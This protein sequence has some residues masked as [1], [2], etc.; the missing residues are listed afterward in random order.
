LS[1]TEEQTVVADEAAP[2][3]VTQVT[4][5]TPAPAAAPEQPAPAPKA[6]RRGWHISGWHWGILAAILVVVAAAFFTIGWFASD[7][8]DHG[9][10]AKMRGVNEQMNRG[11]WGRQPGGFYQQGGT[12]QQG[13]GQWQAYP[14]RRGMNGQ[15]QSSGGSTQQTPATLPPAQQTPTTQQAPSTQTPSTQPGYLGVALQTVTPQVQQQYGLSASSGALVV[16]VDGTGPAVKAGIRQGDVITGIDGTKVAQSQDAVTYIGQKKVG[17][18]VSVTVD[19]NG[20]SVIIQV[21]LGQRAGVT[22]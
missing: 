15:P 18:V 5:V 14:G 7:C 13:P 16:Q 20:Q 19:R 22:G 21:T 4:Q 6:P 1:D 17:D 9:R 2:A 10:G 12:D 8:G 11:G 3:Q